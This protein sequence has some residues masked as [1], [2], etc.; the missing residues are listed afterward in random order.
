M[1][2]RTLT[3][4]ALALIVPGLGH[5]Y[6]GRRQRAAVFFVI[7][8]FM[9]LTGIWLQGRL[10][11]PEPGGLL[12]LLATIGSMGIGPFYFLAL[13]AGAAGDIT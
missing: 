2:K 6:L 12:S 7:V 8:V 13:K 5:F 9:F 10:Y 4:M 3:A 11:T 1:S